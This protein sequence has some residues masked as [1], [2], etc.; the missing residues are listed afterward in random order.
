MVHDNPH[1][2]SHDHRHP[3]SKDH[4]VKDWE[5]LEAAIRSLLIEKGVLGADEI[6]RRIEE[7]EQK[8]PTQGARMVARAWVDPAY[9][10][11]LLAD[12]NAAAGE[13]GIDAPGAKIVA[14]KNTAALHHLVVCTLCSCYPRTVL[15]L[16]PA[17]YKSKAYRSRAVSEPRQVLAEFGTVLAPQ[18]ELRVVDSTAD[19]RY[20]V[21]PARPAG[22]EGLSEAELAALVTRDS[23]IGVAP[24]ASP[25]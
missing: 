3:E 22:S 23:M 6:R 18:V 24:A 2:E 12:A 11:R 13:L 15:G 21:L 4:P 10:A 1:A 25:A 8:S 5:A 20:L 9:E 17:W 7:W 14:L 19:C 16:P